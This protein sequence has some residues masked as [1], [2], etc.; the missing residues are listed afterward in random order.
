VNLKWYNVF[1]IK[2]NRFAL[3][4]KCSRLPAFLGGV[5]TTTLLIEIKVIKI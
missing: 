5:A 4:Y 2:N 1:Y 3:P